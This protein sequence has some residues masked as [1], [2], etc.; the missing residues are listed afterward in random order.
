IVGHYNRF[1][2]FDLRV[3]R[4][5]LQAA[6]YDDLAEAGA[7]DLDG[8]FEPLPDSPREARG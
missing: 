2:V 5:P 3:N 6:R 8:D 7:A 4:R 1:D